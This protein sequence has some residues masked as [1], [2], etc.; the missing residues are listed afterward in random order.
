VLGRRNEVAVE[1][2]EFLKTMAAGALFPYRVLEER[3]AIDRLF[4]EAIVIDS[5][6]VGYAWDSVEYEAVKRSGYSGIQTTLPSSSFDVSTRALA[7]WNE[8]IRRNGDKLVRATK[9]ADI[10]ESK[11]SGRMATVLGFQNATMLE[12][13]VENLDPLFELGAR[14]IQ[15][16]YNRRNLLGDGCTERTNAGLSDYGVAV[17][18]RMNELGMVVDL[19]H[20]GQKTSSDGIAVS[21]RPPAFT[22]TFCDAVYPDHPRAKTD[23]LIKAMSDRGGMTGIACL[24]YFVGPSPDVTLE[25]YVDHVDHAV[26]VAGVDHVGLATDFEIRGIKSWATRETWYEPRLESF[27]PSYRVRWPPWIEGLDEPE[28]FRNVAHALSRRGYADSD[29]E[30]LLGQNWLRF[31]RE[32]FNG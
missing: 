29:V 24:G 19:S 23:E 30:K 17:V 1:R 5:L 4:D 9:A 21:R 27:K 20:C 10:E 2:R 12:G 13:E 16:T 31:F 7:E 15:L 11:R 22:H 25:D 3:T 32:I 6:A 28:R 14:C 18:E 8:R 26:K